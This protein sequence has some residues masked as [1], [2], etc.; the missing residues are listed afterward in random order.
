MFSCILCREILYSKDS[1]AHERSG[2]WYNLS[3]KKEPTLTALSPK[4]NSYLGNCET[5]SQAG[6]VRGPQQS[7]YTT[8]FTLA[9]M[10]TNNWLDFH[11]HSIYI[12]KCGSLLC[13][14]LARES[15][16]IQLLL[17]TAPS[18]NPVVK[19][20]S[21]CRSQQRSGRPV[22]ENHGPQRKGLKS[23]G[24]AAQQRCVSNSDN[25]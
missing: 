21:Q 17:K 16:Q 7:P 12:R 11:Q 15:P 1:L 14:T 8:P 18:S 22:T 5:H 25:T 3:T 13:S 9:Y 6:L 24:S 19:M 4:S 20:W 23:T 10:C 2:R